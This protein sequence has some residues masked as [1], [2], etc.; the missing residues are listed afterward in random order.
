MSDEWF[1]AVDTLSDISIDN[2][3]LEEWIQQIIEPKHEKLKHNQ[4]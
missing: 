1:M 3:S 2:P 4:K